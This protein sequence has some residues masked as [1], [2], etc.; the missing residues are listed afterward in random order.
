[1]AE[2][3]EVEKKKKKRRRSSVVVVVVVEMMI[4]LASSSVAH[5]ERFLLHD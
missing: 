5:L 1:V 2:V 4:G 3:V